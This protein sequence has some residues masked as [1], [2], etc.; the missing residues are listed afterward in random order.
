VLTHAFG[1]QGSSKVVRPV[2]NVGDQLQ[3]CASDSLAAAY[4]FT[5]MLPNLRSRFTALGERETIALFSVSVVQIIDLA[6][7]RTV[8]GVQR[9][10][11]SRLFGPS[12]YPTQ[13]LVVFSIE[14]WIWDDQTM[15][16][17]DAVVWTRGQSQPAFRRVCTRG[18]DF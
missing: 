11:A 5:L 18:C 10:V 7:K 8:V 15:S 14:D 17:S 1:G 12:A 6:L 4:F 16:V 2:G 9:L 3:R 13:E